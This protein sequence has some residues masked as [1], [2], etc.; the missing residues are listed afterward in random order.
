MNLP[1]DFMTRRKLSEKGR[2][3][4]DGLEMRRSFIREV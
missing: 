2:R 1:S 4:A 3:V